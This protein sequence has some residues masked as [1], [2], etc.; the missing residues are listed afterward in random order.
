MMRFGSRIAEFENSW[1]NHRVQMLRGVRRSRGAVQM[2]STERAVAFS[3][4]AMVCF[5]PMWLANGSDI[6]RIR[7]LEN[8]VS[9]FHGRYDGND[10][11]ID[12]A[13]GNE[14]PLASHHPRLPPIRGR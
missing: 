3:T 10:V 12:E 4:P 8:P 6:L 2:V 11:K 1:R 13:E 14:R 5:A 7:L 9:S